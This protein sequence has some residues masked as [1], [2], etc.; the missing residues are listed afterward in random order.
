MEHAKAQRRKKARKLDAV[1]IQEATRETLTRVAK[2]IDDIA[3]ENYHIPALLYQG[4]VRHTQGH[5]NVVGGVVEFAESDY[6]DAKP[7]HTYNTSAFGLEQID[8]AQTVKL[9]KI[10]VL[11][12][13]ILDGMS[14]RTTR[15]R[16]ILSESEYSSYETTLEEI[17][18]SEEILYDEMPEFLK[19]YNKK[20]NKADLMNGRYEKMAGT[21]AGTTTTRTKVSRQ[22][23][24]LYEEALEYLEEQYGCVERGDYGADMRARLDAW[25][26]RDVDFDKG[27]DRTVGIDA[28]A[29]P[30]VRGS[31][32]HFAQSS[33]KPK[34]S[35]RLKREE[36]VL[37][38]LLVVAC[39][40]AYVLPEIPKQPAQTQ[41]QKDTLKSKMNKLREFIYGERD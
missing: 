26:D 24:K 28:D 25:M 37:M 38:M 23:E 4:R 5:D 35:K 15:L 19:T 7:E 14:V 12:N 32:S 8:D 21:N 27:Y 2:R 30:R 33:G 22:A 3:Y 13:D 31:K 10:N 29:I 1:A 40:I 11:M 17:R 20:L 16:S 34:L 18:H 41:E 39:D 6:V 9:H 36:S